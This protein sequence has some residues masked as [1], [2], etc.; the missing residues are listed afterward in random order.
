MHW[1]LLALAL[2]IG[3]VQSQEARYNKTVAQEQEK[4]EQ[5]KADANKR[6]ALVKK[7][8]AKPEN[9]TGKK[10]DGNP[11]E[12]LNIDR[13]VAEYTRQLAIY[14]EDVSR[15]TFW[16]VIATI[17]IASIGI[18]QWWETRNIAK[19]QLRAYIGTRPSNL[20]SGNPMEATYEIRNH[21]QTPAYSLLDNA[22]LEICP[23]PLPPDFPFP[24]L[25]PPNPS[26]TVVHPDDVHYTGMGR[27]Q[28]IFTPQEITLIAAGASHRLYIFGMV[29][30]EDIFKKAHTTKFCHSFYGNP[31][32]Q[33]LANGIAVQFQLKTEPSNQHNEAD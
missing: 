16:L 32:F 1:F 11:D 6:P 21:G 19:R 23:Y 5:R 7:P 17:V 26:L 22:V 20:G 9:K 27:A 15:F 10:A 28:R 3:T 33:S 14:T 18:L 25:P 30:Y 2:G 4:A 31:A 24:N 12:K 29:K 13:Q 8:K